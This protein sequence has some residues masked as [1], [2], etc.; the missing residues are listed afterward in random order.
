MV[1]S[2]I[3]II[4][5]FLKILENALS[6]LRIIFVSN[7]NKVFASIILFISSIIWI[8]SSSITI[9]NI[10]I[11]SILVFSLGSFIGAYLGIFLEE[12]IALGTCFLISITDSD[13]SNQLRNK[14]YIITTLYGSGKNGGKYILFIIIERKHIK[15][16]TDLIYKLDKKAII[17]SEYTNHI[18]NRLI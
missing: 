5:F 4:I 1:I 7:E 11:I 12:K 18:K 16:L 6:T 14:G 9:I 17:T 3:Y 13:I 10:N 15:N 8:L 2:L